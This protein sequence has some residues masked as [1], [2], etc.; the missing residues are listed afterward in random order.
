MEKIDN[1]NPK[2]IFP[3]HQ[4]VIYEPHKRIQEIQ[5]HHENRLKEILAILQEKTL[6]PFKISQIHFGTELD[7]INSFMALSEILGHLIFLEYQN[8]VE[9]SER[10]GKYYFQ[11]I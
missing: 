9:K 4:D 11:R 3:A 2:V 5:E 7:E 6:T 8:K 10:N 1:L